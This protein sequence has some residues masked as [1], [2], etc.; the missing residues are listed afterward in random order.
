M[1]SLGQIVMVLLVSLP[2]T[3]SQLE[4]AGCRS[5]EPAVV[6]L[7]GS[8]IRK[9]FPGPPNYSDIHKGDRA[10]TYFLLN[11]DSPLCL[12]TDKSDPDLRPSQKNVRTVQLVLEEGTYELVKQLSGK[13]VVAKRF[14]VCRS[15]WTPSHT[16][17]A[18]RYQPRTSTLE[19]NIPDFW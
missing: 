12:N 9:T 6:T 17:L 13:K 3:R 15:Y 2:G 1:I 11:L 7:H 8:L 19:M 10:E 14:P 4:P 18:H 5:Y 16:C